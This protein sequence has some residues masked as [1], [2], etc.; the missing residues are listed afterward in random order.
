MWSCDGPETVITN[1]VHADGSITRRV[2][3]R[4]SEEIVSPEECKVPIDSTWNTFKEIELS[5]NG[6]TTWVIVSEKTFP[7]ADSINADYLSGKDM[8]FFAKRSAH[9]GK[10]FRWFSTVYTFTEK[11]E[12]ILQYGYPINDYLTGEAWNYFMLP[13]SVADELIE[14]TDSLKYKMAADSVESQGEKWLNATL[15]SGWFREASQLLKEEGVDSITIAD[16]SA[17]EKLMQGLVYDIMD[18][19]PVSLSFMGEEFIV[20]YQDIIERAEDKVDK[21][22][23]VFM[24]FSGYTMQTIMPGKLI[25]GNGYL[26]SSGEVSWPVKPELF[27]CDDY[28]MKAE[29]RIVNVPLCVIS[30]LFVLLVVAGYVYRRLNRRA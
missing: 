13:Q 1:F 5:E 10:K 25:R 26:S 29:S 14:G 20:K 8:N 22:L 3:M 28:L 16:F 12:R 11:V 2:E 4:S 9:F 17:G 19:E 27:L 21:D 6:D 18:S 30:A 15:L 7:N 23:E 24:A